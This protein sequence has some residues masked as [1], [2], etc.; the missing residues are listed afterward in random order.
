MAR[1]LDSETRMQCGSQPVPSDFLQMK[2]PETVTFLS[3][4]T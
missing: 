3:F 4:A 1:I 2:F